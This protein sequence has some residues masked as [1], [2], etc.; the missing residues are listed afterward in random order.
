MSPIGPTET[1]GD[2]RF[3]GAV[4]G[5]ADI[6]ENAEIYAMTPKANLLL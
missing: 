2:V 5:I 1:S 3:R 4:E 6:R